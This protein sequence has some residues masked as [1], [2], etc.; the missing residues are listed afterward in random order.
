MP[1]STKDY[2]CSRCGQGFPRSENLRKH[3]SRKT[4]CVNNSHLRHTRIISDTYDPLPPTIQ[5]FSDPI[6]PF[7]GKTFKTISNRNKHTRY[8]CRAFMDTRIQSVVRNSLKH[9]L[10]NIIDKIKSQDITEIQD[11]IDIIQAEINKIA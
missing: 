1:H 11:T 8:V 5:T 3:L 7:C 6:C 9:S 4:P 2:T 10:E